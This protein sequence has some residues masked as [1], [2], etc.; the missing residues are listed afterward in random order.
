MIIEMFEELK[1]FIGRLG[2]HNREEI[3][4]SLKKVIV[5]ILA[6]LLVVLGV[7]TK[8]IKQSR[9]SKSLHCSLGS[10]ADDVLAQYSMVLLGKNKEVTDAMEKLWVLS[11]QE[12]PM[13]TAVI[14]ATTTKTSQNVQALTGVVIISCDCTAYLIYIQQCRQGIYGRGS[15]GIEDR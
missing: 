12:V 10:I 7:A 1:G 3:T 9:P 8:W 14:L 2:V 6:Q 11:N 4:E 15:D 5:K 13:V